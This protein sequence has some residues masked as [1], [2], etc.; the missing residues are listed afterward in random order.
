MILKYGRS[1]WPYKMNGQLLLQARMLQARYSPFHRVNSIGIFRM[2]VLPFRF[3]HETAIHNL[4]VQI[5][6]V[7]TR[8]ILV[9]YR[10]YILSIY[11]EK[12]TW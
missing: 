3:D 4:D 8:K 11:T 9:V 7:T 1:S 6:F 5:I 12:E 10:N 2:N